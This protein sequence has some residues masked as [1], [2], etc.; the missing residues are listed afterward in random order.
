[1]D[2]LKLILLIASFAFACTENSPSPERNNSTL[3]D[4]Q[5]IIFGHFYGYCLGESCIEV[6]RLTKDGLYEDT[7]DNYPNSTKR[8]ETNFVLLDRSKFDLLKNFDLEIP[9]QLLD[10]TNPV[11]GAPDAADGG[12]IYLELSDGRFWLLDMNPAYLPEYLH[13]LRKHVI[14][15]IDLINK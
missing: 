6:F 12:G 1:M 2:R 14:N 8:L 4:R 3:E 7:N 15:A 13:P 11:I 10:E 9:D 5:S